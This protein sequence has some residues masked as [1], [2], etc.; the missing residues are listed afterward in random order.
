MCLF[1]Q[2]K[3]IPIN[4]KIGLKIKA[5][6]KADVKIIQTEIIKPLGYN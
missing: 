5:L 4:H 2:T 3:T 6:L 1:R